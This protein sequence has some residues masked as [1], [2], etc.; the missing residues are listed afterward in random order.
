MVKFLAGGLRAGQER[1]RGLNTYSGLLGLQFSKSICLRRKDG[2]E[3]M[4]NNEGPQL[5]A[6]YQEGPQKPLSSKAIFHCFA[7]LGDGKAQALLVF[8]V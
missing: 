7:K 4:G 6:F 1:G 5:V 8:I 3:T 2:E